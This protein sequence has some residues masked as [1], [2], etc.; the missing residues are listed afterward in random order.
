MLKKLITFTMILAAL[1][2]GTAVAAAQTWHT[3]NQVTLAWDP[4]PPPV[5]PSTNLPLPGEIKYQCYVKFQV[6][7]ATPVAVGSEIT[8]TQQVISFSGEGRYYLCAQALRYPP[9]ETEA[10]KSALSCTHDPAVT[11]E[12]QA[13]GVK[14]F[15]NP[16]NPGGMRRGGQ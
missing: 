8:A 13:F 12:N 3:A 10:V 11:A 5:D 6:V 9:N 7:T 2:L 14:Y 16:G 15:V 4:V 1:C